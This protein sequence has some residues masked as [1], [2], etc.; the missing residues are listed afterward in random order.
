M[1]LFSSFKKKFY[2]KRILLIIIQNIYIYEF[3][4]KIKKIMKMKFFEIY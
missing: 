2:L 4:K 1:L 3:I